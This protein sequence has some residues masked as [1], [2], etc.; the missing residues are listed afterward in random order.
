MDKMAPHCETGFVISNVACLHKSPDV[1]SEVVTQAKM[2]EGFRILE[3]VAALP[4]N[5][6]GTAEWWRVALDYDGYEGFLV[7]R[8]ARKGPGPWNAEADH[9]ATVR[10]LFANVYAG[11][12]VQ[13]QLLVTLPMGVRVALVK[14]GGQTATG[15]T[16]DPMSEEWVA[17]RLADG[18]VG[19]M[20]KSDLTPDGSD[21][22]G[23]ELEDEWAWKTLPELR[24]SLVRTARRFLGIPY[25]WG[26]T[27]SFG[28]DCSGLVQHVYRLHGLFLP[29]DANQQAEY[30]G[31]RPV[32]R[33]ELLPGDLLFF[34]KYGHVGMAV[35][36][37]EFI[38]ATTYQDPVVQISLVD[39]PHWVE[40]RDEVRRYELATGKRR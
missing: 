35:S 33:D 32:E 4:G 36:H 30:E 1:T 8:E 17:V 14:A 27:S 21:G 19:F 15:N 38:H 3:E 24:A 39:D 9:L 2:G 37:H 16:D 20:Q 31:T 11:P 25:R 5:M 34:A 12:K 29:R 22:T 18:R 40:L 13:R 7:A 6:G 23:D 26:G 10:N 28:L